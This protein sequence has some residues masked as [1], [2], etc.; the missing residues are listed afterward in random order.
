MNKPA[1]KEPSMDEILS[2][3]RQIIADEDVPAEADSTGTLQ[4]ASSEPDALEVAADVAMMEAT[5][6]A[7]PLA[8]PAPEPEM[9]APAIEEAVIEAPAAEEMMTEEPLELSPAQ[10]IEEPA[11]LNEVADVTEDESALAMVTEENPSLE[12]LA[13]KDATEETA[14]EMV[15]ADDIAF[16]EADETPEVEEEPTAMPDP[17]LSTHMAEKLLEPT[18]AAAVSH[19]FSKLGALSIGDGDMTLD[20]MLRDM[21]RPML[22]EWLDENLPATVER[23]VEKEIERVSRG[24]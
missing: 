1:S 21:L 24:S 14:I 11:A 5:P 22:K 9:A 20:G 19:T 23:M 12:P 16:D 15:I 10:I 4:A 2:S 18:T 13:A 17:N 3:I 6:A 8:E 7:P